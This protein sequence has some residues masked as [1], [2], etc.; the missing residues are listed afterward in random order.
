[1]AV[2]IAQRY[3]KNEKNS[4]KYNSKREL[5]QKLSYIIL[6][7]ICSYLVSTNRNIKIKG[8]KNIKELFDIININDYKSDADIERLDFIRFALD[9]RIIY[10]ITDSK[11]VWDY[12][13]QKDTTHTGEYNIN[14]QEMS[15]KDVEYVNTMVSSLLDTA[16][17]SS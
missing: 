15:N 1:M 3:E 4:K 9:A 2:R 8:Y 17:F 16:T 5:N 7:M 13:I 14:F 11:K 10:G 12:I 6:D